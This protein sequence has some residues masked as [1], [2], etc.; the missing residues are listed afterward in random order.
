MASTTVPKAPPVEE[1][2]ARPLA[3]LL[4]FLPGGSALWPERVGSPRRPRRP[5]RKR[6]YGRRPVF[7]PKV[8]AAAACFS[9]SE[10]RKEAQH[11]LRK[12]SIN[13]P[14]LREAGPM[15]IVA[16]DGAALM[17]LLPIR[18]IK[19]GHSA[20]VIPRETK[21]RSP[22]RHRRDGAGAF[23][24]DLLSDRQKIEPMFATAC[25]PPL[26]GLSTS[27]YLRYHRYRRLHC[28]GHRQ[29]GADESRMGRKRGATQPQDIRFTPSGCLRHR[30]R[31]NRSDQNL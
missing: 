16:Q 8:C 7:T 6:C 31:S 5:G 24:F 2:S 18:P 15:T 13:T 4:D 30:R 9:P 11:E 17:S 23:Y 20:N 25:S 26:S 21:Q 27:E 3:E 19:Y 28:R 29:S 10:L 14:S 22:I 1:A 12:F